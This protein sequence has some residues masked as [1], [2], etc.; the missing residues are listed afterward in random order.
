MRLST[1]II[2]PCR[3]GVHSFVKYIKSGHGNGRHGDEVLSVDVEQLLPPDV[4]HDL[5]KPAKL[6]DHANKVTLRAEDRG[7]CPIENLRER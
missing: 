5:W 2:A 6:L 3:S 1:Y 4:D 7:Q